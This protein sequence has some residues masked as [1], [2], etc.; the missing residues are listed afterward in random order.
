MKQITYSAEQVAIFNWFENPAITARNLVVEALAGTGK[1][2][3]LI[4]SMLKSPEKVVGYFVFGKKNQLEAAGKITAS[5]IQVKTLHSLGFSFILKHW[6]GVRANDWIEYER[7]KETCLEIGGDAP[8]PVIFPVKQ[9]VGFLKNGFINPTLQDAIETAT[10]RDIEVPQKHQAKFPL[11]KLAEIA[12][13]VLEKSKVRNK[14]GLISFDDMVWLPVALGI[15]TKQFDLV[16]VDE[17]QDMNLPQLTM[18]TQAVKDGGRICLVGDNR[19]AI[20]G[21]RGACSGGMDKFKEKLKAETLTLSV[22]YRCPR[23][24]VELAKPFVPNY[25]AHEENIEGEVEHLPETKAFEKI[26]IGDAVLSRINAPLM[27]IC[28]GFLKRNI[29]ARIEGRDIG[30]NLMDIINSIEA[31]DI[32]SFLE[33][34]D[35]WR[36]M[37]IALVPATANGQKKID[38][39]QDQY[40]TLV[41]LAESPEITTIFQMK[42]K[43]ETLFDDSKPGKPTAVVC[44]SV[45]RAKGL[46]WPTV[47]IMRDTF[48]R[49]AAANPEQEQEE[50][51]IYYVAITRAMKRLVMVSANF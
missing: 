18:A 35:A 2:F 27:R 36:I 15:V 7:C 31:N 11:N 17:C 14:Q 28:L 37:K 44:S 26:A 42:Q 39:I 46:E 45:H 38:S 16:C 34:L 49:R 19:Q 48:N 5:R 41:A 32:P 20:F 22:T 29:P 24:V 3:T 23:K 4:E 6:R 13:A 43:L 21:F 50:K 40:E 51:N 1:T 12:M 33:K 30:K 25:I 10:Y 9:L 47:M 8:N